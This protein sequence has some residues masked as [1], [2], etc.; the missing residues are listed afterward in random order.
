MK[1]NKKQ[2]LLLV[3][4]LVIV[5]GVVCGGIRMVKAGRRRTEPAFY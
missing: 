3:V 1:K 5:I 2:H 4:L